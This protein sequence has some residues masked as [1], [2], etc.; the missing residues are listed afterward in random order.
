MRGATLDVRARAIIDKLDERLERQ[1]MQEGADAPH[2]VSAV[3][4]IHRFAGN[5]ERKLDELARLCRV[6]CI[7]AELRLLRRVQRDHAVMVNMQ[8][9]RIRAARRATV[10]AAIQAAKRGR[11]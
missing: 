2:C 1:T 4:A 3:G 8:G 7:A 5:F 6:D 11:Q 10:Q 9:A